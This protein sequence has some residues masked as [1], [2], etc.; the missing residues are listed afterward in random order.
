MKFSAICLLAAFL[1]AGVTQPL[2][3]ESFPEL[4]SP[5]T[6]LKQLLETGELGDGLP[7]NVIHSFSQAELEYLPRVL[8]VNIQHREESSHYQHLQLPETTSTCREFLDE[9][10]DTLQVICD[11]HGA[12]PAIL[13][14]I[15]F[16]ESRLGEN[17]GDYLVRDLFFTLTLLEE[18]EVIAW[19]IASACDSEPERDPEEVAETV[20]K[21]SQRKRK[22]ALRE[23][24]T[25]LG[26]YPATELES[27]RGSWAGA[28]GIPQFLP[29]SIKGYGIDWNQDGI[30]NLHQFG[31]A[32][33]S[34]ANYLA[35]NG[36]RQV[37]D[38]DQRRRAIWNYNH[39]QPYVDGVYYLYQQLNQ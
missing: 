23:L 16:T 27:L 1:T 25:L 28:A 7:E 20:R 30:V 10:R 9:Q 24:N 21:R 15:W 14:A 5:E 34:T 4:P 18:P 32:A 36:W 6:V 13:S 31:D 37:T 35:R 39:S 12:D 19:N 33:A 11:A 2:A 26:L 38:E 3:A 22:W 8:Q 17:T 29:S